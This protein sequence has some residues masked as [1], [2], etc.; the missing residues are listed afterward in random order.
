MNDPEGPSGEEDGDPAGG[1]SEAR[2]KGPAGSGEPGARR[3]GPAG[4]IARVRTAYPDRLPRKPR[5]AIG[6]IL[7]GRA[8]SGR[9]GPSSVRDG[10]EVG[11]NARSARPPETRAEAAKRDGKPDTSAPP[12]DRPQT[13]SESTGRAEYATC[14]SDCSREQQSADGRPALFQAKRADGTGEGDAPEDVLPVFVRRA[15]GPAAQTPQDMAAGSTNATPHDTVA[16]G[17]PPELFSDAAG[18][19]GSALQ[20]TADM[21]GS[22]GD[23]GEAGPACTVPAGFGGGLAEDAVRRI[24][25]DVVRTQLQGTNGVLF[26]RNLRKLV[27]REVRLMLGSDGLD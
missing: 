8:P 22:T 7:A 25:A 19:P 16:V 20:P 5:G 21:H 13:L 12:L 3:F 23:A 15:R 4:P 18:P 6:A 17:R 11:E 24:V 1:H 10:Q 9:A 26:S 2:G 27:H 14:L